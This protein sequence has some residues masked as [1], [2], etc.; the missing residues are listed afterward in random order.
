[1]GVRRLVVHGHFTTLSSHS[2][3]ARIHFLE[4]EMFG[5]N[6]ISS[7]LQGSDVNFVL[8]AFVSIGYEKLSFQMMQIAG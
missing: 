2:L 3:T 4:M 8:I 1:M 6:S 7:A 5:I